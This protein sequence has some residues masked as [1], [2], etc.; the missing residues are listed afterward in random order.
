[1]S[2]NGSAAS[3][4]AIPVADF[5]AAVREWL[6]EHLPRSAPGEPLLQWDDEG[7]SRDRALQRLLW[8]SGLA[9]ITV[10]REYGG[11][12]LT[13]AH[14]QAL[15]EE[16]AG[17]R[18]P[19][20]FGIGFN[21]VLPT[22]LAH[23]SEDLKRR[24]V[25][26]MLRGDDIW[27]QLLSEPSSG[28]D[29]AG[30][31]TRAERD[32]D[33]WRLNGS[34][35]WTTGGNYS[36]YAVCLA[37]TDP[38][39]PKHAGLTMFVV[40]MDAPGVT[41]SPVQLSDGTVD[42]CQ[43]HL[44]DVRVPADAV[45]GEVDDG[46]RVA[47]T[48]MTN[49]RR[50]IGRGWSMAAR[51]GEHEQRGIEL[52]P[53]L[54]DLARETGRDQDSAVRELIGEQWVLRAVHAQTTKRVVAAMASGALPGH[55]AALIKALAAMVE[56]RN[57]EIDLAV[58]GPRAAAWPPGSAERWGHHRLSSHDIGGGTTE[59]Q[60]NAIAERLL[61]LPRE[62]AT[63]RELPFDQLRQNTVPREEQA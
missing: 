9:G 36:Q 25:P 39:V 10:P 63:D 11:R 8:E 57:G 27:C 22:L 19:E 5:R 48:M 20:A 38:H 46:W 59:M 16:A 47:T 40:P 49:E 61:G 7:V 4:D 54:L 31:L 13:E 28:S 42:F 50:A 34:K 55:G 6:P 21:V 60:R 51:P 45:L 14:Q 32:G 43:E 33:G 56:V 44:D 62:P 18:M 12:G 2:A 15:R 37:R 29:L 23:G 3:S 26:R 58:A 52:T 1:M 41:V 24:L 53:T 35:I 17:Y 30:L